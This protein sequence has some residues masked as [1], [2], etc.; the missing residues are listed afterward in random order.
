MITHCA[1]STGAIVPNIWFNPIVD[2]LMPARQLLCVEWTLYI[3]FAN[4]I[5][6]KY[7]LYQNDNVHGHSYL[8]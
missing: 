7:I 2:Q 3:E 5:F 4:E 8:M 6:C 1:L